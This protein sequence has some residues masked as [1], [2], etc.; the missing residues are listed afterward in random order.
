MRLAIAMGL[1]LGASHGWFAV[2]QRIVSRA[3][4]CVDLYRLLGQ[5][6]SVYRKSPRFDFDGIAKCNFGRFKPSSHHH[7][8][9]LFGRL[10]C[11]I[12]R[13]SIAENRQPSCCLARSG[14]GASNGPCRQLVAA[15]GSALSQSSLNLAQLVERL[16]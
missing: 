5:L 10:C 12:S 15:A 13:S 2:D 1:L 14:G 6:K 3:C 4:F 8:R 9:W 11:G 16:A 7:R